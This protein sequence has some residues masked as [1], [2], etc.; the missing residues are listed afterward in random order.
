MIR[1]KSTPPNI[2]KGCRNY[3]IAANNPGVW[4]T[5]HLR[6]CAEVCPCHNCLV[7]AMCSKKCDKTKTLI[8]SSYNKED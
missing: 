3:S 8:D 4:C 7:K 6:G 5:V 1:H 2:C